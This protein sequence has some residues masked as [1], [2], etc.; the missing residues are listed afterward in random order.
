MEFQT[1][2]NMIL[3]AA[4]E[5]PRTLSVLCAHES[6][7]FINFIYLYFFILARRRTRMCCFL[8]FDTDHAPATYLE[9]RA[10]RYTV[11]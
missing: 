11:Q 6:P 9:C 7:F 4:G 10:Y 2:Y 1:G 3:Y 5:R 8:F